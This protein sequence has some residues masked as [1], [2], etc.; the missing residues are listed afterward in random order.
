MN[1][2]TQKHADLMVDAGAGLARRTAT[3]LDSPGAPTVRSVPYLA[4]AA[5][6]LGQFLA[7]LLAGA[8]AAF[9]VPCCDNPTPELPKW[10]AHVG[11]PIYFLVLLLPAFLCGLYVKS[12]PILVG[13]VA[14]GMGAF[15]WQW[16]GSHV[17]ANLFPAWS[18]SRLGDFRKAFWIFVSPEFSVSLLV[19][20]IC[21]AA[22]G[23]GAASG[24]YLLR[25]PARADRPINAE[26]SR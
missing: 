4:L 7:Y 19:S 1:S 20:A 18:V 11:P 3:H 14:A 10:Y 12:R 25:N 21:R 24:G 9:G 13:A 23:A 22:V 2:T 16:L 6:I 5:A 26:P 15:I 17:I 8:L